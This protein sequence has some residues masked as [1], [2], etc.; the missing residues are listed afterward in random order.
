MKESV[1]FTGESVHEGFPLM[2]R[3]P[4]KPDFDSL[5]DRYPRLLTI[6]HHLAQ[7]TSDGLPESPY[8]MSLLEFDQ[9]VLDMLGDLGF[10][11]LVETFAGK[12]TYYIYITADLD[13]LRAIDQLRTRYPEHKIEA[14]VQNGSGWRVIRL[15][16]KDYAFYPKPG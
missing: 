3:F 16:S 11:V 2:L 6:E 9:H 15:Y 14:E 13:A 4:A 8:N 5:Q 7:V 1:W 12:R 10:P